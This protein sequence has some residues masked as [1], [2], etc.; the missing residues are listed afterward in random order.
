MRKRR[1]G[2]V[3]P[4]QGRRREIRIPEG[5][6]AEPGSSQHA[7]GHVCVVELGGPQVRLDERGAVEESPRQ[8]DAAK[9]DLVE[10][11]ASQTIVLGRCPAGG[12]LIEN[13]A[14]QGAD[15]G[16]KVVRRRFSREVGDDVRVST[17]PPVPFLHALPKDLLVLRICHRNSSPVGRNPGYGEARPQLPAMSPSTRSPKRPTSSNRTLRRSHCPHGLDVRLPGQLPVVSVA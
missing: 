13:R 6:L 15:V 9:V 11:G 10:V 1:A 4:A 8:F 2:Q 3:G 14:D 16:F 12:E 5:G 7:S 17:P